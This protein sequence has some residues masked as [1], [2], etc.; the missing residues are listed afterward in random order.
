MNPIL[1]RKS[2]VIISL[3]LSKIHNTVNHPFLR[4]RSE[5]AKIV[6]CCLLVP[7]LLVRPTYPCVFSNFAMPIRPCHT[8]CERHIKCSLR[9][10]V[11]SKLKSLKKWFAVC[12]KGAS[13]AQRSNFFIAWSNCIF[14]L[15]LLPRQHE[16]V[17]WPWGA[18][19]NYKIMCYITIH[20][21]LTLSS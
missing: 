5:R 9:S 17:Q 2:S 1:A 16:R 21:I 13:A 19:N 4:G 7:D 10:L 15:L 6:E 3:P 12:L 8:E 14:F 20:D 18:A 11:V